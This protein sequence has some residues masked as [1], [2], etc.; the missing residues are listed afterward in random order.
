MQHLIPPRKF[1]PLNS[2]NTVHWGSERLPSFVQQTPLHSPK[3]T[4]W[5]GMSIS[6]LLGP[7]FLEQ[8]GVAVTVDGRRYKRMLTHQFYPTVMDFTV[9]NMDL[10]HTFPNIPPELETHTLGGSSLNLSHLPFLD[11]IKAREENDRRRTTA[12]LACS[13]S[14]P[15]ST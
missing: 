7:F 9:N 5:V 1:A 4:I 6:Y 12:S 8:R 10:T 15:H 2:H 11:N 13:Q 14:R 3:A